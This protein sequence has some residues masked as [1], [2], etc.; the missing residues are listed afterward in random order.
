MKKSKFVKSTIILIIGGCITKIMSMFIRIVMTRLIGTEGIGIYMLISPTFMLLIAIAQFGFPV[1]I[2]KLVSENNKNNKNLVLSVIPFSLFINLLIIIFLLFTSDYLANYLLKEPRTFYA[3]ICIGFVLPFIS[4]SSIIRGYFFG[5]EKMFPHVLSNVVEDII[6]LI[7]IAIGVPIFL[8]KGLKY[9]IA[10][11]VL[12]NIFSELTSIITLICFLPKKIHLT[13]KDFIPDTS[14]IKDV[15]NVSLPTTGSRLIGSIG[16]FLEPIILTYCLLKSGYTNNFIV[17]QYGI[18]NGYV[19]TLLL[20][21]SFFTMAISQALIPVVSHAYS[22][23]RLEYTNTKIKQALFFSL[24]IG[25]PVTILFELIPQLPLK[26]IYNTTEGINYVRVLAPIFLLHYIQAPLTSSLQAMGKAKTAMK[27]T[28]QGMIIRT[29]L[30]FVCSLLK[31][32]LWGL[33]IAVSSN[34][35]YV[36]LHHIIEVKRVLKKG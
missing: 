16:Y 34:I 29:I 26:I 32:G 2:S 7:V 9:A 15:L 6:R 24:L 3:L 8:I 10:F 4:I 17:Y 13:K 36:T 31:I 19:M 35:I 12:S 22:R 5:K 27:G 25:V 30:L 28:L 11:L 20:L 18:V 21:P 1:A 33:I 23:N 14:N